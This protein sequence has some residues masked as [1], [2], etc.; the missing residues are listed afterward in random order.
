MDHTSQV[1]AEAS[2]EE[3]D[4]I[5]VQAAE[6]GSWVTVRRWSREKSVKETC[7]ELSHPN[8]HTG[9]ETHLQM[10]TKPDIQGLK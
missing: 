1:L 10:R 4:D 8:K 9:C 2:I 5:K 3:G 6:V 7:A